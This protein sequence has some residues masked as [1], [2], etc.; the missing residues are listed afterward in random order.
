MHSLTPLLSLSLFSTTHTCIVESSK[1]NALDEDEINNLD[2]DDDDTH[3]PG[4]NVINLGLHCITY[5]NTPPSP[6]TADVHIY[7]YT[8]IH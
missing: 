8:Y 6:G 5:S 3:I 7:C 4:G 1:Q 2:S